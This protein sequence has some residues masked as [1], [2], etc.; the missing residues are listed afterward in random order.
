MSEGVHTGDGCLC[1]ELYIGA[2][3]PGQHAG[4]WPLEKNLQKGNAYQL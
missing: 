2:S 3:G 4:N 1:L